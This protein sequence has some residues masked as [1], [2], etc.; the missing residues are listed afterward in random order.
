MTRT[1]EEIKWQRNMW[2]S[3]FF[4]LCASCA[5]WGQRATA[6]FANAS[7][8]RISYLRPCGLAVAHCGE[9]NGQK[10]LRTREAS[11]IKIQAT[12][13]QMHSNRYLLI[14]GS[15][16]S[17]EKEQKGKSDYRQPSRYLIISFTDVHSVARA[18]EQPFF[19]RGVNSTI[20]SFFFFG[21]H[22]E[23]SIVITWNSIP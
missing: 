8:C 4:S 11:G 22:C 9:R 18:R 23:T 16:T 12:D 5:D 3:S 17:K 20:I 7:N 6:Q 19:V 14:S 2:K 1:T 10:S 13:D 21:S 15:I